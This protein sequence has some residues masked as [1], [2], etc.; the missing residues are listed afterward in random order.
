[1]QVVLKYETFDPRQDG[2][3]DATDTGTVGLNWNLKGHD[4]KLLANYLRVEKEARPG[5]DKFLTRLQVIF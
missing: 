3:D 1:L 4:L 5:E 2:A